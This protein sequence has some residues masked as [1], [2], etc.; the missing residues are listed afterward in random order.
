MIA[1]AYRTYPGRVSFIH[2][3]I[4]IRNCDDWHVCSFEWM[5][6]VYLE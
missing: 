6:S 5:L 4:F 2:E 3:N 1:M